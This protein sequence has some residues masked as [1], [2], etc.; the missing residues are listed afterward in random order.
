MS[1]EAKVKNGNENETGAETKPRFSKDMILKTQAMIRQLI[2]KNTLTRDLAF[3]LF[4][5]EELNVCLASH[6]VYVGM[7]TPV[8]DNCSKQSLQHVSIHSFKIPNQEIEFAECFH[9]KKPF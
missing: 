1:S 9:C 8:C 4:Q 6:E 2:D 7:W 5:S 3:Q